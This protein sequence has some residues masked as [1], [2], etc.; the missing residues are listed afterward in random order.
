M[1]KIVA[2]FTEVTKRIEITL[3]TT[4]SFC[5]S[6]V[7]AF[8]EFFSILWETWTDWNFHPEGVSEE[9]LSEEEMELVADNVNG[10]GKESKKRSKKKEEEE[11]HI[12]FRREKE[13]T[14]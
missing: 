4:I 2:I 5:I 8:M 11:H 1:D 7:N 3:N 6:L 9:E 12:G 13:E 10:E 14:K